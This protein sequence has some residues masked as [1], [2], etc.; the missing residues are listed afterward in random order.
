MGDGYDAKQGEGDPNGASTASL[1]ANPNGA[2]TATTSAPGNATSTTGMIGGLISKEEKARNAFEALN[3]GLP[4]VS[5]GDA[6]FA[7]KT[8]ANVSR[9]EWEDYQNRFEPYEAKLI[10]QIDNGANVEAMIQQGNQA[11]DS[12]FKSGLSEIQRSNAK[13]GVSQDATETGASARSMSLAAGSAKAGLANTVRTHAQDRDM[14][15]MA[16]T[17]VG[18]MKGIAP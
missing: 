10:A 8:M 16:G 5:T 7:S 18:G 13:F 9:A 1:A 17:N 2:S 3:T 14:Q 12:S 11:V 6:H 4:F 15:V